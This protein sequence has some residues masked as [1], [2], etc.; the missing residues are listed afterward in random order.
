MLDRLRV[1]LAAAALLLG[2]LHSSLALSHDRFTLDVLWFL[3]SGLAIV[4][5]ALSNLLLP[6]ARSL[7]TDFGLSVQNACLIGFFGA[8][9][10]VLP[11]PQVIAGGVIFA[12]LFFL[13][14]A[15]VVMFLL[16]RP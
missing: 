7:F 8:A 3:G 16:A 2:A 10:F 13:S 4:C 6:L 12:G 11:Q 15:R 9:W 5:V 14:A 1:T